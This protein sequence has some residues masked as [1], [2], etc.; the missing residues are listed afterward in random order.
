[1]KPPA[2]SIT[3]LF[4]SLFAL[5][6]APCGAQAR[7]DQ[8]PSSMAGKVEM[9]AATR[10]SATAPAV[11]RLTLAHG[12]TLLAE[13]SGTLKAKKLKPGDRVKAVLTQDVIAGGKLVAKSE[14]KLVG[15]VTEVKVRDAQ[16]PESRLGVVFDKILLKHHK[17]VEIEAVVQALAPPVLRRSRVDEPDQMMPPPML[18]P[19]N[20]SAINT[21][22][23]GTGAASASGRTASNTATLAS[24]T[25]DLGTITTVQSNPGSNPGDSVSS[26][27]AAAAH[28]RPIS[29]GT[30]VHGVY[31]L[32]N[33]S[34][35]APNM[36][37]N[38][39][40]VIVS[41]KSDVKLESGTQLVLLVVS[42]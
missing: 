25:N 7:G 6:S 20:N 12:T 29:G 35:K 39:G 36:N 4:L 18:S 21:V 9:S 30:G 2:S 33:L 27:R 28:T 19:I 1:M 17:E 34:L 26:V 14:S 5:N 40:P 3:F 31:G 38:P 10:S 11:N 23:R 15:H 37:S 32:K 8:P 16:S 22:G 13:L 42:K 24:V 41:T